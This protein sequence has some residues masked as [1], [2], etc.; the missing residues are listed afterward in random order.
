MQFFMS[1]GTFLFGLQEM[2][3]P[4]RWNSW[5]LIQNRQTQGQN[6]PSDT[7]LCMLYRRIGTPACIDGL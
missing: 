2:T 4:Q 1:H 5:Q 3:R 6:R 7:L